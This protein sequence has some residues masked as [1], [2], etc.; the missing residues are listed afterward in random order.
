MRSA[1]RQPSVHIVVRL[2]AVTFLA[3]ACGGKGEPPPEIVTE[4]IRHM[5][6]NSALAGADFGPSSIGYVLDTAAALGLGLSSGDDYAVV[7]ETTTPGLRHIRLQQTHQGVPVFGSVVVA[8]ADD[9]T[10][11][12]FN[13]TVTRH[14]EGFDITTTVRA[15]EAV[16][17]ARA[18]Q[19]GGAS[20]ATAN[21]DSRLVILPDR[22]GVGARTAWHVTF[23][24]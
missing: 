2:T 16:D 22:D 23:Y 7:S 14:L 24:A 6:I 20:V 19:A 1:P 3:A 9:T 15:G 13:G 5:E 17:I 10:Y 11:L 8:H 12:G 21:E 4:P 18:D